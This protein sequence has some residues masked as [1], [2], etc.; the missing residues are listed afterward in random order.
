MRI[1][2]ASIFSQTCGFV[3]NKNLSCQKRAFGGSDP[4]LH[5]RFK[6]TSVRF[7]SAFLF[8]SLFSLSRSSP[9]ITFFFCFVLLL[10][11]FG[12]QHTNSLLSVPHHAAFSFSPIKCQKAK[13]SGANKI[14]SCQPAGSLLS[15]SICFFLFFLGLVF[16]SDSPSGRS[17][18]AA[19]LHFDDAEARIAHWCDDAHL[20]FLL[21]D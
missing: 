1:V 11:R 6:N 12:Q 13:S 9:Q 20:L 8:V 17:R 3:F 14:L 19:A 7:L 2:S 16:S 18:L 21:P 15:R 10:Q 4:R 5:N